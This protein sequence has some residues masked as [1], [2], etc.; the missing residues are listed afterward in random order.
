MVSPHRIVRHVK[1]SL[2]RRQEPE[3]TAITIG[4]IVCK[5]GGNKNRSIEF[6]QPQNIYAPIPV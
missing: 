2:L 5:Q 4:K 1:L 6:L 3:F